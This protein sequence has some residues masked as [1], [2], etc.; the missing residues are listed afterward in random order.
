MDTQDPSDIKQINKT[1]VAVL[2]VC[3]LLL[4]LL[5]C[6]TVLH[7]RGRECLSP[8]YPFCAPKLQMVSINGQRS[9]GDTRQSEIQHRTK[10]ENPWALIISPNRLDC[11][12]S[13]VISAS[14]QN[15]SDAGGAGR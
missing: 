11:S 12:F 10:A 2:V 15:Q 8:Q 7:R 4:Y 5:A 9:H 14:N 3:F 13:P 1:L 6:A